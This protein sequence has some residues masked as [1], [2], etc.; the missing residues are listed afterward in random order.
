MNKQIT[1]ERLLQALERIGD[2]RSNAT[3]LEEKVMDLM[4]TWGLRSVV[5]EACGQPLSKLEFVKQNLELDYINAPKSPQDLLDCMNR[6]K[7]KIKHYGYWRDRVF[8]I[9]EAHE[10]SG[11]EWDTCAIEGRTIEFPWVGWDLPLIEGDLKILREHK[12][13]VVQEFLRSIKGVS[14][15]KSV[16]DKE[17]YWALST[18]EEVQ[19]AIAFYDWAWPLA[20][21][22]DN[23]PNE[24]HLSLGAGLNVDSCDIPRIGFCACDRMPSI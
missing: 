14:L 2:R 1:K 8:A 24:Y 23:W 16:E 18:H 15:W 22:Y 10:I 3:G 21:E 6:W 9:Q 20:C 11:I 7:A 19:A 5:S 13:R 17:G 4:T 12:A